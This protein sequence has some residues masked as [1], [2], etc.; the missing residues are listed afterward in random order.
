MGAIHIDWGLKNIEIEIPIAPDKFT[1]KL[2]LELLSQQYQEKF[3]GYFDHDWTP[4]RGTIILINDADYRLS[5][6]EDAE[7]KPGDQL[8]FVPTV[9][10]G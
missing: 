7:L 3:W 8:V 2:L 4:K 1:L 5:G 10:G 6:G 9:S